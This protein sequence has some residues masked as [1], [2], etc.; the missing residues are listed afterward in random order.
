MNEI[1]HANIFFFIASL[2]TIAF[3]VLVCIILYQ[4]VRIMGTIRALLERIEAGSEMIAED[5]TTLR[6]FV[7]KGGLVSHLLGLIATGHAKTRTRARAKSSKAPD[8]LIIDDT[9]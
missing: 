1:L 4:V 2:A 7:V 5:V 3:S 8:D 6:N 9:E